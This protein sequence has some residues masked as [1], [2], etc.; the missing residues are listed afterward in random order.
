MTE[1]E[2]TMEEAGKFFFEI[3]TNAVKDKEHL[4]FDNSEN[5]KWED[6][7]QQ[8]KDA[9]IEVGDRAHDRYWG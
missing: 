8:L 6:L 3:W 4:A 7:N 1:L 9:W 5:L 2:K